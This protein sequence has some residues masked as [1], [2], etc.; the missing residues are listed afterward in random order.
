PLGQGVITFAD[1]DGTQIALYFDPK[2]H[3]LSKYETLAD[4]PVLGDTLTEVALADYR[5]VG[6]VKLP[7]RLINRIGGE[8]VQDLSYSE[9]TVNSRPSDSLFEVPATAEKGTPTGPVTTVE[10]TKL[11]EGVY[12][13]AGSS[14]NSLLVAFNDYLLLVEAPQSEERS[15]AVISKIKEA[16][17]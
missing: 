2:T 4:N 17:P 6:G 3:L 5:A 14:H 12:F 1:S 9:V 10:L 15:Q 13:V 8:V 11:A 7:F 16:L